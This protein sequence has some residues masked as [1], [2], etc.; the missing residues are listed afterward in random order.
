MK[1]RE[2]L[3]T[4][5]EECRVDT[6]RVGDKWVSFQRG[7]SE[8]F[9]Q[10]MK[11]FLLKHGGTALRNYEEQHDCVDAKW[12]G[13][14]KLD[15]EVE[16][17]PLSHNM[18]FAIIGKK[19]KSPQAGEH[20]AFVVTTPAIYV[21]DFQWAKVQEMWEKGKMP[22]PAPRVDRATSGKKGTAQMNMPEFWKHHNGQP[23]A[24]TKDLEG[25]KKQGLFKVKRTNEPLL[26]KVGNGFYEKY[27]A[28][29]RQQDY[30]KSRVFVP[31]PK[32][33][34]QL[35]KRGIKN[36]RTPSASFKYGG[37]GLYIERFEKNIEEG[38]ITRDVYTKMMT[39]EDWVRTMWNLDDTRI[40]M[41]VARGAK[42]KKPPN[43]NRG[44]VSPKQQPVSRKN[45]KRS[46]TGA[47]ALAQA[48]KARRDT[49]GGNV[50]DAVLEVL[51]PY[52]AEGKQHADRILQCMQNENN[53]FAMVTLF[54]ACQAL[55]DPESV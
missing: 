35:Q 46:R 5:D 6:V 25:A 31:K 20:D 52:G 11:T 18:A 28:Y 22:K 50:N 14:V 19:A 33:T 1:W 10:G 43:E 7:T 36:V 48:K 38:V 9:Y 13:F 34:L 26:Y 44:P 54:Q 41:S 39:C 15:P 40:K 2:Y 37:H 51:E 27:F 30:I 45:N 23:G 17:T 21:M 3:H 47:A 29:S 4:V 24:A 53:L 49:S 8:D 32:A 42:G 55:V 12:T 16:S